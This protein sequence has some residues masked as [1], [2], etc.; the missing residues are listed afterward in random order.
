MQLTP[1]MEKF[2]G[3]WGEMGA[4]WGINRTVAQVHALL[5]ISERPLNAEDLVEPLA[6]ARSNISTSVKELQNWGLVQITH[7]KGD[8]RDHFTTEEDIWTMFRIIADERKRR[9]FDPTQQL[10][11]DCLAEAKANNEMHVYNKLRNLHEFFAITGRFYQQARSL[12]A[13]ALI[14]LL[15][16]G[17][18]FKHLFSK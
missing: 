14:E 7:I 16:V 11:A 2:I 1:T 12:P 9:E 13:K 5:Y 4:K 17:S 15:K 10:L 3:H 8:R 18:K 6:V